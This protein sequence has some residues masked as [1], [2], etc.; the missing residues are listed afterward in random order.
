MNDTATTHRCARYFAGVTPGRWFQNA[1]G[2][3]SCTPVI[4]QLSLVRRSL[5]A[6]RGQ[7]R[8]P[9]SMFAEV[10]KRYFFG[11]C[12]NG[13][14]IM[15]Y[16]WRVLYL[17]RESDGRPA[18]TLTRQRSSRIVLNYPERQASV[19]NVGY[20]C[21]SGGIRKKPNVYVL[22]SEPAK[23][24]FVAAGP[25]RRELIR[26][27]LAAPRFMVISAARSRRRRCSF[28][29]PADRTSRRRRSIR[30]RSSPPVS[31]DAGWSRPP[32]STTPHRRRS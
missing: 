5:R 29:Y 23:S 16:N 4:N 2:G 14:A 32:A 7:L 25:F 26:R 22:C 13:H 20:T 18:Q 31:R 30:S 28:R 21:D 19:R 9:L 10:L 3:R 12:G 27:P 15:D 1:C 8:L 24:E 6:S 17:D 11:F